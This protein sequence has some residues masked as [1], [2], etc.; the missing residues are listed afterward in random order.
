MTIGDEGTVDTLT[1]PE[2]SLWLEYA[3]ASEREIFSMMADLLSPV[4]EALAPAFWT[5]KTSSV[6]FDLEA[7]R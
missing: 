7:A 3:A 1:R 4:P 5:K 2:A 6:F